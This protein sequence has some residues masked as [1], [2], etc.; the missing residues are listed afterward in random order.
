[1]KYLIGCEVYGGVTGHRHGYLKKDGK[2]MEFLTKE[3]AEQNL[4][5][6]STWTTDKGVTFNYWV[7][8]VTWN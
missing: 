7:E 6:P 5:N 8:E 1:M 4:P 2:V 3:D